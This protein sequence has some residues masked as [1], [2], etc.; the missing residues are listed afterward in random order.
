MTDI[1]RQ[2]LIIRYEA[3][4]DKIRLNSKDNFQKALADMVEKLLGKYIL[5]EDMTDL[6][7]RRILTQLITAEL[8]PAFKSLGDE[9]LKEMAMIGGNFSTFG[10]GLYSIDPLDKLLSFN[11]KTLI[12]SYELGDL[13]HSNHKDAIKRFKMHIADGIVQGKGY[14]EVRRNIVKSSGKI[15]DHV[16]DIVVQG[17]IKSAKVDAMKEVFSELES[18]GLIKGYEWVATLELNTCEDCARLD[19]KVWKLDKSAPELPQHFRC[20]CTIVPITELGRS[21]VR[22]GRFYEKVD[23]EIIAGGKQYPNIN[24]KEW[25]KLQ[26][27]EVQEVIN[28]NKQITYKRFKVLMKKKGIKANSTMIQQN[29]LSKVG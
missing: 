19:G 11:K 17:A 23:G 22:S 26:P 2:S 5:I 21:T 9:L 18:E 27:T 16:S 29:K 14:K 7:R 15:Y 20:R 4:V 3:L 24:Y 13:L 28:K 6:Q 8:N 12:N 10:A 25:L 1:E